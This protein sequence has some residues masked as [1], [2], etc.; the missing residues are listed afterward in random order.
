VHALAA[1]L[2]G[3]SLAILVQGRL[4]VYDMATGAQTAARP[5]PDVTSGGVCRDYYP[6]D[7][8]KLHVEDVAHGL[9][10]YVFDG[11]VHVLRLSDGA[12]TII[13]AGTHAV[14]GDSGLFYSY[15]APYPWHGRIRFVP[16]ADLTS[17]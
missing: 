10:T 4:Q 9:A 12:D 1:F 7:A 8:A 13:A 3:S 6:C 17:G 5:L 11:K 15:A 2:A 16:I 14:F